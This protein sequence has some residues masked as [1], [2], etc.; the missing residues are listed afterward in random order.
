[1][2]FIRIESLHTALIAKGAPRSR[3]VEPAKRLLLPDSAYTR[4]AEKTITIA[5]MCY[6]P[7]PLDMA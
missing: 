2:V 5:A 7:G 6:G 3:R 1:M 4:K